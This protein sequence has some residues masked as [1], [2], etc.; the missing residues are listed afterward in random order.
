ME[1]ES[2]KSIP[3]VIHSSVW[4]VFDNGNR[5]NKFI[6]VKIKSYSHQ[7]LDSSLY[8]LF[9]D[10]PPIPSYSIPILTCQTHL[11][12]Y[13]VP[14]LFARIRRCSIWCLRRWSKRKP[15]GNLVSFIFLVIVLLSSNP[16]SGNKMGMIFSSDLYS[17]FFYICIYAF[18]CRQ[19]SF[20]L[21]HSWKL[22]FSEEAYIALPLKLQP[23]RLQVK[24]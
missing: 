9:Y 2:G 4:I 24:L 19:I 12:S 16:K 3:Y 11:K 22:F 15:Y 20:S 7:F 13:Y 8:T 21:S 18:T 17:L 1:N 5:N 6:V 23:E 10:S 14:A